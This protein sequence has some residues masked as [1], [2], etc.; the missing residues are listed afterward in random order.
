MRTTKPEDKKDETKAWPFIRWV[1]SRERWM[2][3]ARTKTGGERR[4]FTTK[5]EAQTFRQQQL[6]KRQGQ[7]DDAFDGRALAKYGWKVSDA[8]KFALEHLERTHASVTID[9]AIVGLIAAKKAKGRDATYLADVERRLSKL[10]DL[11]GSDTIATITVEQMTKFF[12][13]LP[14]A[15]ETKNTVRRDCVTLWSHAVKMKWAKENVAQAVERSTV[16][17]KPPGILTVAQA[18]KLL[19]HSS[20]DLLAFHAIGLF[21][22]LRVCEL[23]RLDWSDV[24]LVDGHIEVT[25]AKSKTRTRRFVPILDNLRAWITPV[26]KTSG[27]VFES[28]G[29]KPE[30]QLDRHSRRCFVC[31]DP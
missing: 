21:A 29:R 3:D 17:D 10:A 20:G 19:A 31:V 16:V 27:S 13:E 4:F 22:G 30:G 5:T 2:V 15:A 11:H 8:I 9:E 28:N 6:N 18:E 25:A 12:D 26:A 1:A 24:D 23:K 7:G 14:L